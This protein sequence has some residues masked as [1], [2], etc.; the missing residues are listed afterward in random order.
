VTLLINNAAA[1]MPQPLIGADTLD[2]ARAEMEVNYFGTLALCR[3]FA[4]VLARNGGGAIVNMLSVTSWYTPAPYGSYAV[5]KAAELSMTNG[6]R[7][8]LAEQG[9]LV[10]AVHASTIAAAPKDG[11]LSRAE[12]AALALDAV[13]AGRVEVLADERS[14]Q[15]KASLSNEL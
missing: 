11:V 2:A 5:S 8:E 13:E 9:T 14:R 4:P 3:A 6:V 7:A 12:V 10:V 1:M 15:V